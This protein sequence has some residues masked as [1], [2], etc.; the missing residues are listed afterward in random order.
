MMYD[1]D[2][3]LESTSPADLAREFL[4]E[5]EDSARVYLMQGWL[6]STMAT[7]RDARRR[8]Q[9]TQEE[10]AR[11]LGTTQSAVARLEKDHEGRCSLQ[12]YVEY[13]AACDALPLAIEAVPV[14]GLRD[15]AFADPDAPR[16]VSAYQAWREIPGYVDMVEVEHRQGTIEARFEATGEGQR[17][18]VTRLPAPS[19]GRERPRLS[20][21]Q[22]GLSE[23]IESAAGVEVM[24]V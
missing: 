2:A 14:V 13:L 1:I 6:A 3:T 17:Y 12:R 8:A 16:T 19:Q 5:S 24:A 9:L 4:R 20:L 7:L 21:L 23:S 15:Y 22:G 10:V 11:R 18:Q